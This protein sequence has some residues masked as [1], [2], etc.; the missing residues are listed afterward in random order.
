MYKWIW[1]R[2]SNYF[3]NEIIFFE[4]NLSNK[5]TKYFYKLLD[6]W[7]DKTKINKTSLLAR[8]FF[9][10]FFF[11]I[12]LDRTTFRLIDNIRVRLS[13]NKINTIDYVNW[14][15]QRNMLPTVV[16]VDDWNNISNIFV[17]F[18]NVSNNLTPVSYRKSLQ[19]FKK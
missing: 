5:N 3:D 15:Q 12:F 19:A 2:L 14:L 17:H 10:C 13:D 7:P 4:S 9:C 8:E 16:C 6:C 18:C 1:N 11:R